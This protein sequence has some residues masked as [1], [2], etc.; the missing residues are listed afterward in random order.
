M[1]GS[2]R[3]LAEH[4]AVTDP[5]SA[6]AAR[7][8]AGILAAAEDLF[9]RQGFAATRLEQVADTV[10]LTRAALFYY[11]RDKQTLYDAMLEHAFGSLAERLE[12]VLGDEQTSIPERLMLAVEAWVDAI[13]ARPS[14]ARLIMRFVAD[15]AP[16]HGTFADDNQTAM[17][18]WLLFEQGRETG[19]LKP[20]H[21]NPYHVA[22]AV[23]GTTIFFVAALAA[24]LPD[25]GFEPLDPKE[26]AAHKREAVQA[27]RRLLGIAAR[28]DT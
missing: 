27:A 10:E 21:D 28:D 9:S 23:I 4:A 5:G 3:D 13:V 2:Q 15:G 1:P 12:K 25:R 26:V 8:R 24:L 11:Y 16:E 17:K 22:S 19:E 20:L 18:F 6:R 14:L 7:T